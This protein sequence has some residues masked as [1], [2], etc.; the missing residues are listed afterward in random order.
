MVG[1][2]PGAAKKFV[3]SIETTAGALLGL[4]GQLDD[5]ENAVTAV[6]HEGSHSV[7]SIEMIL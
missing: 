6:V 1:Q 5:T 3:I 4:P 7:S 2:Y